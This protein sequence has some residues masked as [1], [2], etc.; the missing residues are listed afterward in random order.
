[1]EL[2]TS[3]AARETVNAKAV[4]AC[5][6]VRTRADTGIGR[7]LPTYHGGGD[8]F[9]RANILSEA[10]VKIAYKHSSD[11]L[12]ATARHLGLSAMSVLWQATRLHVL[13]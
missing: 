2:V 11:A 7:P 5:E 6:A 9:S 3:L 13:F 4:K 10:A 12:R 1:M 8:V